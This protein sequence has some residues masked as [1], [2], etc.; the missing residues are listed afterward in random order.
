M[1]Q[2]ESWY[3]VPNY[4]PKPPKKYGKVLCPRIESARGQGNQGKCIGRQIILKA[5]ATI[6]QYIYSPFS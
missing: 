2:D 4:T 1:K 5:I 6:S 3:I